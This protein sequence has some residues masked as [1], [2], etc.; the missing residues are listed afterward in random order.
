MSSGLIAGGSMAGILIA[1]LAVLPLAKT[2]FSTDALPAATAPAEGLTETAEGPDGATYRVWE[3]TEPAEGD[4]AGTYLV[5][6]LGRAVQR[7]QVSTVLDAAR[8]LG[9]PHDWEALNWPAVAAFLPLV[10]ILLWVGLRSPSMT[11]AEPGDGNLAKLGE[12]EAPPK[13]GGD[14]DGP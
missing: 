1:L 8:R 9:L 2:Y 3:L 6:E 12:I 10:L 4:H 5:D 14:A 7:V 13:P 11:D